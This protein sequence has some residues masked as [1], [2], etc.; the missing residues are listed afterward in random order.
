MSWVGRIRLYPDEVIVMAVLNVSPESFYGG[1]VRV[2]SD[3][4]RKFVQDSI[5][6]G[7]LIIDVG[8]MSTAPYRNTY[9][10]E[11]IELERVRNA[12]TAINEL[13]LSVDISIDSQRS[14]VVH[15]ALRLGATIVN[16]VSGFSDP[17]V[18]RHAKDMSASVIAVAHGVPVE[19]VDPMGY[20]KS[21]IME[22]VNRARSFGI[23]D[24]RIVVDPAIGFIRP[25][26]IDSSQWDSCVLGRL[27]ELKSLGFP[28]LVGV[29]RKSFIGKI[30]GEPDPAARLPGSMAAAVLSAEMGANIIRAHDVRE[31]VQALLVAEAILHG[32]FRVKKH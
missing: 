18:L 3:E 25:G 7:A 24:S 32:K 26:W 22:A 15:E 12:I 10:S 28:V 19:R 8:G 4:I 31:T 5:S 13:G 21:S 17:Q 11:D 30:A 6:G 20:V 2:S 16:D 23:D 14:R 29:S 27:G 9:V 1:S